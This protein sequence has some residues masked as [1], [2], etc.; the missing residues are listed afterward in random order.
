MC[1]IIGLDFSVRKSVRWPQFFE[2]G[3]W[4]RRDRCDEHPFSVVHILLAHLWVG[5][6]KGCANVSDCCDNPSTRLPSISSTHTFS[7][8]MCLILLFQ[9]A[10]KCDILSSV[11]EPFHL[12]TDKHVRVLRSL[13]WLYVAYCILYG[14]MRMYLIFFK[15]SILVVLFFFYKFSSK[16]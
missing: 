13:L 5:R 12:S 3:L 11:L 16:I 10:N 6:W 9:L 4:S 7:I 1:W 8:A 14:I 2:G 15:T